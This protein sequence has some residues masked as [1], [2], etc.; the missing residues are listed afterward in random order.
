M[1]DGPVRLLAGSS[2]VFGIGA[3]NDAQTLTSR[4]WTSHAPSLPWLN[5]GGRSHNSAQELLLF[6][7]YRHLLREVADVV[8]FSGFNNLGLSRLPRSLQGDH[9]AFFNCVEFFE[10]ME[11][12]RARHRRAGSGLGRLLPRPSVDPAPEDAAVPDLTQQ[13][14]HAAELTTRHL[15]T[16]QALASAMGARLTFVL[17]PLATWVREEIAPQERL[18]FDELDRISNF[19][20]VYG[21]IATM[22]AGRAY[23]RQLQAGC[24]RIGVRFVDMSPVIAAAVKPTDW[25]FVDRI[26]FTDYGHDVVSGLLA[27]ELGLSSRA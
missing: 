2:T 26:H 1:P 13:I 21:E 4:L 5:F 19:R 24:E 22:D 18:L 9:G 17:Q 7:L 16:W 14:A 3:S 27:T 6:V 8:I 23:A 11:G 25:L 15:R 10:Q 20:E 12:L